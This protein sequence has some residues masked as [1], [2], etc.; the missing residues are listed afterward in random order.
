LTKEGKN[1]I[2]RYERQNRSFKMKKGTITKIATTVITTA[3]I[4]VAMFKIKS[5]KAFLLK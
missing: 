1:A 5:I 2:H 4:V 3:I